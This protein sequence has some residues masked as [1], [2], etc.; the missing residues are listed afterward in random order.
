MWPFETLSNST[1]KVK[2][3]SKLFSFRGIQTHYVQI[4]PFKVEFE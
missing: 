3:R 4:E 2:Q 1:D